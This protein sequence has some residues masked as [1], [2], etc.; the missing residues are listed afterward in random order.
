MRDNKSSPGTAS[1]G[2]LI[3]GHTGQPPRL[4]GGTSEVAG[5]TSEVAQSTSEV[6]LTLAHAPCNS[7]LCHPR[8]FIA[9]FIWSMDFLPG[10]QAPLRKERYM[11]Q[12]CFG[13]RQC[14]SRIWYQGYDF[15]VVYAFVPVQ[16]LWAERICMVVLGIIIFPGRFLL[17]LV[18]P[19][20]A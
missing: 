16:D 15:W 10:E 14:D 2:L 8:V 3:L 11:E 7:V 20:I 6:F 1:R 17:L 19:G 12:P 4:P 18:S 5:G 13:Y 9:S